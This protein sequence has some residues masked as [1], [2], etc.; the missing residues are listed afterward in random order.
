MSHIRVIGLLG[1]TQLINSGC[2]GLL[3]EPYLLVT[4]FMGASVSPTNQFCSIPTE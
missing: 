2:V 1:R 4:S 3:G